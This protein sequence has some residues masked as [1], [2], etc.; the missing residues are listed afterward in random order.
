MQLHHG[1]KNTIDMGRIDLGIGERL[2]DSESSQSSYNQS[3]DENY[4]P[5]SSK[6]ER[7]GRKEYDLQLN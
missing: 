4:R 2:C 5:R 1:I 6:E 7:N 3:E